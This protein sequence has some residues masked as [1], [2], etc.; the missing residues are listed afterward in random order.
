MEGRPT[1]LSRSVSMPENGEALRIVLLIAFISP[2]IEGKNF[3]G[4]ITKKSTDETIC[5]C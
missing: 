2:K 4:L 5:W 3:H 1:A